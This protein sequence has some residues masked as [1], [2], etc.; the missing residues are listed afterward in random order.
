MKTFFLLKN[1]VPRPQRCPQESPQS[2]G[3]VRML[4][5]S[6]A[7]RFFGKKKR[8]VIAFFRVMGYIICS[9]S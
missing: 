6:V 5:L 3:N 8:F 2:R 7:D 9:F 1:T 4:R